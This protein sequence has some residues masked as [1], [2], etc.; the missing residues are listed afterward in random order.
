MDDLRVECKSA[1]SSLKTSAF[2]RGKFEKLSP[3]SNAIV[4]ISLNGSV[5][6]L[7]DMRAIMKGTFGRLDDKIRDLATVINI[8]EKRDEVKSIIL[9]IP[10][11]PLFMDKGLGNYISTRIK[12]LGIGTN[13]FKIKSL[14]RAH[15]EAHFLES[16]GA[17]FRAV[18]TIVHFGNGTA[19][20]KLMN[21]YAEDLR[22]T[23]VGVEVPRPSEFLPKSIKVFDKLLGLEGLNY[24]N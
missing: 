23:G 16:L 14:N 18:N 13:K 9:D 17:E 7:E 20:V 8:I 21:Y 3:E 19:S 1:L 6:M 2:V 15:G 22:K 24:E 4:I 12:E 11:I 10:D 5:V